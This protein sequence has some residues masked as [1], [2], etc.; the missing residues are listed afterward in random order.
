MGEFG[1]DCVRNDPPEYLTSDR[2]QQNLPVIV[3]P[4]FIVR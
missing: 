3:I 1:N 2:D 4:I